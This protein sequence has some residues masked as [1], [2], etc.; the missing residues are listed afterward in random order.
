MDHE[1]A[2]RSMAAEKYLLDELTP[3]LRE[4]FEEHFFGCQSCAVDVRAGFAFIEHAKT[5]LRPVAE[6]LPA[7]VA[8]KPKPGWLAWLRPALAVP[9]L[10]ILLAAI[11]Y[12]NLVVYPGW[13]NAV[14][15]ANLPQ[16]LGSVSLIGGNSRSG[17][18]PVLTIPL[19]SPFLLS[20]DVPTEARFTSYVADLRT[21]DEKTEWSV[22]ISPQAAKDTVQ[23][24][25]PARDRKSGSYTLVVRGVEGAG[26]N[27]SEVIRYPFEL[28]FQ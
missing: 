15:K 25:V 1:Q 21:A 4:E 28:R 8:A 27:T 5:S 24:Q 19:G 17:S 20:V 12:Q 11:G 10:A 23:I 13:R 18:A 14:A 26:G 22:I 9:A 16:V 6:A 7:P 2:I 3:E